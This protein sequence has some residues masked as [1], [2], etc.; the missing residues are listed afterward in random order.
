MDRGIAVILSVE[1]Y[2]RL[3]RAA[4]HGAIVEALR[5]AERDVAAGH[6]L[7]HDEMRAKWLA[8]DRGAS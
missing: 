2:E 7:T 4:E 3:Q 8:E 5:Q 1:E 6:V